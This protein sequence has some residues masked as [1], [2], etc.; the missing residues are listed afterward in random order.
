MVVD[1]PF[2]L[3]LAPAQSPQNEWRSRLKEKMIAGPQRSPGAKNKRRGK[4]QSAA[5]GRE[6][7]PALREAAAIPRRTC[8]FGRLLFCPSVL[9]VFEGGG[10]VP[11]LSCR[12]QV[13]GRLSRT[14]VLLVAGVSDG[15]GASK[16]SGCVFFFF[17]PGIVS[18]K[19]VAVTISP[20]PVAWG[21]SVT[22][23]GHPSVSPAETL[24]WIRVDPPTFACAS[25]QPVKPGCCCPPSSR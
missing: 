8:P 25:G 10:W 6:A 4:R 24:H 1:E 16:V 2:C 17:V 11:K 22:R 14:E 3:F 13:L 15:H 5:L 12:G 20:P 9:R 18:R 23:N 7:L 21:I 19:E